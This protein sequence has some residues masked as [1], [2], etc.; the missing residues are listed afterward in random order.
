VEIIDRPAIQV[1]GI[2]V[3]GPTADLDPALSDAWAEVLARFEAVPGRIG[4][5]V[6]QVRTEVGDGQ[7]RVLVGAQVEAGTPAPPDMVAE[8]VYEARWIHETH[9]GSLDTLDATIARMLDFAA[10]HGLHADGVTMTVGHGADSSH[11]LYV[12]LG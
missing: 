3:E 2:Q 7:T 8:L 5:V 6:L 1:V 11:D 12:R 9:Q 10:D 4:D